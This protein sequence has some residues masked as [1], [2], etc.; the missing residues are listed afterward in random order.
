MIFRI[1]AAVVGTFGFALLFALGERMQRPLARLV[2]GVLLVLTSLL[3]LVGLLIGVTGA[4]NEAWWAVAIG[5][6]V[7]L[8]AAR[9]GWKI[10]R[11]AAERA[12]ASRWGPGVPSTNLLPDLR[13]R[14]LD[15]V[16]SWPERQRARLAR[17]H[18]QGFLA[19]R[20]SPSLTH[21][22]H[23]LLVSLEKRVPELI[24]TCLDRCRRARTDERRTYVAATLDKLTQI[25]AE[26]E[27][28]RQE[29]RAADDTRLEV[30][31][32]Y[33]DTVAPAGGQRP[34]DR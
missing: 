2:R 34:A 25:G 28:A 10:K 5:G 7:L 15:G 18:I 21:E 4:A 12:T 16:L 20:E 30:L 27:R 24:D 19:E 29:V 26:A 8:L 3:A 23:A 14:K 6:L 32:R 9:L 11:L 31:H 13:W 1:L 17:E 22:H 33:F